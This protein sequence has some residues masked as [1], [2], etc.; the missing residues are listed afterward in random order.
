MSSNPAEGLCCYL[1][2]EDDPGVAKPHHTVCVMERLEEGEKAKQLSEGMLENL[3]SC[4][5]CAEAL[6][7]GS[8]ATFAEHKNC[9]YAELEQVKKQL[10]TEYEGNRT[11]AMTIGAKEGEHFRT[12]VKRVAYER[13]ELK[14]KVIELEEKIKNFPEYPHSTKFQWD[15][16]RA[17]NEYL[18]EELAKY[19]KS[20]K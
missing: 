4:G 19:V 3:G 5:A 9:V 12:A 15:A 1:F 7:C 13:D 11:L 2:Y 17:R 20:N 8:V 16:L 14:Y 10:N 6:C 18:E